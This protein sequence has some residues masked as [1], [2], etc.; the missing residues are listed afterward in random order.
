MTADLVR[1]PDEQREDA[2]VA[3]ARE[4]GALRPSLYKC[5]VP[6]AGRGEPSEI[7]R[8]ARAIDDALPCPWVVLS[9]GFDPADFPQAVE[10]V[11]K[12]GASGVLAGRAAWTSALAADDPAELLRSDSVPRLEQLGA[13]VDT[14]GRP[15]RDK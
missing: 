1:V 10:A 4:L 6:L 11:C 15:G 8:H 12:G 13:T 7:T 2:I 3:A 5:Q 9:R 14:H